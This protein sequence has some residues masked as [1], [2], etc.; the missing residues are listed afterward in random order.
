MDDVSLLLK[1]SELLPDDDVAEY[2]KLYS[3]VNL[4]LIR[5]AVKLCFVK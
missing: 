3:D 5:T 4:N 1:S 2:T